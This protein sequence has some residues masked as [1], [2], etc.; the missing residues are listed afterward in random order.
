MIVKKLGTVKTKHFQYNSE[1]PIPSGIVL[2]V[3][4]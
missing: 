4:L 1:T 3:P 2:K